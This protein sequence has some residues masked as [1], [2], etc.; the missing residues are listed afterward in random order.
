MNLAILLTIFGNAAPAIEGQGLNIMHAGKTHGAPNGTHL[1]GKGVDAIPPLSSCPSGYSETSSGCLLYEEVEPE[2]LC[3]KETHLDGKHCVREQKSEPYFT[4]PPGSVKDEKKKKCLKREE[5]VHNVE[6]PKGYNSDG[7]S[8]LRVTIS[9]I[10][11]KCPK[12][13]KIGPTGDCFQTKKCDEVIH[14]C[15]PGYYLGKDKKFCVAY[16]ESEPIFECKKGTLEGMECVDHK[17]ENPEAYCSKHHKLEGSLC[18]RKVEEKSMSRCINGELEG[19]EC[20]YELKEKPSVACKK[21]DFQLI[22]GKCVRIIE[23]EPEV[24]CDGKQHYSAGWCV[25]KVKEKSQDYCEKGFEL[26]KDKCVMTE[27]VSPD[28]K[29][30]E[31]DLGRDGKCHK[32]NKYGPEI[33]CPKGYKLDNGVCNQEDKQK[34]EEYCP[35]DTVV[36]PAEVYCKSGDVAH[37]HCEIVDVKDPKKMCPKGFMDDGKHCARDYDVAGEERCESGTFKKGK[38]YM[39][40]TTKPSLVCKEKDYILSAQGKCTRALSAAVEYFCPSGYTLHKGACVRGDPMYFQGSTDFDVHSK[41][42]TH[43]DSYNLIEEGHSSGH[44]SEYGVVHHGEDMRYSDGKAHNVS[45]HH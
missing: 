2:F 37:D 1:S 7:V 34:P 4:C 43:H 6:C 18:V 26:S 45:H 13:F 5:V 32:S 36:L 8:C 24:H 35:N 3:P 39:E 23:E 27:S 38:C 31:G 28:Y 29:C 10:L 19:K 30:K 22:G 17:Y 40:L 41:K 42:K 9:D 25:E 44:H 21:K 11:Y 15:A 12:G 33:R 14:N 16:H 20:V